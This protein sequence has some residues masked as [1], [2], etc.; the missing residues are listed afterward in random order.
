MGPVHL[1]CTGF[2]TCLFSPRASDMSS[3]SFGRSILDG[4]HSHYAFYKILF[5]NLLM[6]LVCLSIHFNIY[7]WI[8][9]NSPKE[10]KYGKNVGKI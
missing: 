1:T 3:P 2:D 6:S 9:I 10:L 4:F 8:Y 7:H 5:I